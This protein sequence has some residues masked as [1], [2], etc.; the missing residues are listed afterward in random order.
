[1][2]AE[3]A[4][5]TAQVCGCGD[6][7]AFVSHLMLVAGSDCSVVFLSNS[8]RSPYKWRACT[9]WFPHALTDTHNL[10]P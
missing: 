2:V 3:L 6:L 4:Y 10:P 5:H 9:L 1:M 7:V 8:S